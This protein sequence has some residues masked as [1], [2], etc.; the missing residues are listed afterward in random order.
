M[1]GKKRPRTVGVEIRGS[2]PRALLA[3]TVLQAVMDLQMSGWEADEAR[4]WLYS[5]GCRYCCDILEVPYLPFLAALPKRRL[6]RGTSTRA[7]WEDVAVAEKQ[8]A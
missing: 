6:K 5:S 4:E 8:A 1:A 3:A 7:Y 2:G